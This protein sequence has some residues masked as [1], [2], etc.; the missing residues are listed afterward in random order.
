MD[1]IYFYFILYSVSSILKLASAHTFS[2]KIGTD[3]HVNV[4]DKQFLSFTVDPKYLFSNTDKYNSKE[5]LCMATSLSPAYLRIAGPSTDYMS[6]RNSSISIEDLEPNDL[7]VDL[8]LEHHR[9]VLDK[10]LERRSA[11]IKRQVRE[12]VTVSSNQWVQFA[13][14]AKTTGFELVFALNNDVKTQTG[15]W[16]PNTALDILTVAEKVKVGKMYWQ[17]GYECNNQSIEEYL[18]DLETLRLIVETFPSGSENK[19]KVVGGDVTNCLQAESKSDFKDYVTLSVD[20]LDA[21]LL[22]SNSSSHELERMSEYDRLKLL[23]LLSESDTPLWITEITRRQHNELERAANWMASL[24]YSA[25]NGFSVHYRE[26]LK[27]ELFE[28]TLSFYMALLFKNLVGE[29]VLEVESSQ[30]VIFAHCTSLRHKPVHGA[31]TLYAV[32]MEDEPARFSI[33]L[34]KR[35]EGGDVMQFILGHDQSGNIV[36]NGRAMYYEGDIKP[37]VKRVRPYKTLLINLPPKSFGFWVLANTKVD[38]CY[39]TASNSN[40]TLLVEAVDVS[41]INNATTN[42]IQKRAINIEDFDDLNIT[43]ISEDFSDNDEIPLDMENADIKN[44]IEDLNI[45]LKKVRKLFEHNFNAKKGIDVNLR[46]KRQINSEENEGKHRKFKKHIIKPKYEI[47]KMLDEFKNKALIGNILPLSEKLHNHKYNRLDKQ[48]RKDGIRK[49][50]KNKDIKQTSKN[51]DYK[52]KPT[53]ENADK[54]TEKLSRHRRNV[55]Y[56]EKSKL[57]KD[58]TEKV[59]VN[60]IDTDVFD[61]S[62]LWKILHK[63]QKQLNELQLQNENK[64]NEDDK[65][66]ENGQ[67]LVKTKVFDDGASINLSEHPNHGLIKTTVENMFSVLGELNTNLNRFWGALTLLD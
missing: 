65:S 35:E 27:E 51:I 47:K 46:K 55:V 10:L 66:G 45:E 33:K 25:R 14:W 42:K 2:V 48:K 62:K 19:W 13:K 38:A 34:S 7:D 64:Y 23:K 37:I 40:N 63:M 20:M 31:V 56:N 12:K 8:D 67:I 41:D 52:M 18:N 39:N 54:N 43:E 24:G 26:L 16:D 5:C 28:P 57:M 49:F 17:L 21:V 6:F 61:N 36:V 53:I 4:V 32:N 44:R 9:N 29:R 22:N 58:D 59:H 1:Y 3:Q 11:T 15:M 30:A 60:E 50:N